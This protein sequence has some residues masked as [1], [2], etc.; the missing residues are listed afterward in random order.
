MLLSSGPHPSVCPTSSEERTGFL[1]IP[2][3]H[4]TGLVSVHFW[5]VAAPPALPNSWFALFFSTAF[6]PSNLPVI[7]FA[8]CPLDCELRE[9]REE[10]LPP[11]WT[12]GSLI[13][14]KG[15]GAQEPSG[16]ICWMTEQ[17]RCRYSLSLAPLAAIDGGGHLGGQDHLQ[18]ANR[19]RL[20][21]G[22]VVSSH[23]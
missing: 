5:K 6:S 12:A 23:H 18:E 11:F 1:Q 2:G 22:G 17:D 8:H 4:C 19:A 10:F 13:P 15:S 21:M 16:N 7:P 3:C 9:G 20:W 14:R